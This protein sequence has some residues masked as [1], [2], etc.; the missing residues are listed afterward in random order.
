[1]SKIPSDTVQAAQRPLPSHMR[2]CA[3]VF[4]FGADGKTCPRRSDC[5]RYLVMLGQDRQRWPDGY[6]LSIKV[7]SGLCRDGEEWFIGADPH[8]RAEGE[9]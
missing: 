2:R 1:M 6:P 4:E 5:A 8:P 7:S 3:G 9:R